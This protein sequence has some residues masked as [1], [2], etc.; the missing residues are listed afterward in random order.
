MPC[1]ERQLIT[2]RRDVKKST[3]LK[4]GASP[5]LRHCGA[6][7][8]FALGQ[9]VT[10][11]ISANFR[12]KYFSKANPPSS[13]PLPFNRRTENYSASLSSA[14]ARLLLR[15]RVYFNISNQIM[16]RMPP[17]RQIKRSVG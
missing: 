11:K 13:I 5:N 1:T 14:V 15:S 4:P 10:V 6:S 3:G 2:N 16:L 17:P 9:S 7:T 8:Q 12:R